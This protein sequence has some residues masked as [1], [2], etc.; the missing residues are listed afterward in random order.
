MKLLQLNFIELICLLILLS[1]LCVWFSFAQ[2][3]CTAIK[4]D[5]ASYCNSREKR[6][7]QTYSDCIDTLQMLPD[8][9]ACFPEKSLELKN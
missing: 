6:H 2:L 7:L 9:A 8:Y 4:E 3:P 1:F 5:A